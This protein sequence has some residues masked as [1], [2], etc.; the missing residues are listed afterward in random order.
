M[1]SLPSH[2]LVPTDFSPSSEHALDYACDLAAKLGATVHVLNVVEIP[3]LGVPELG[4]A[5][6]ADVIDHMLKDNEAELARTCREH[7]TKAQLG[8]P[9]MR[10]GDARDV[11][12]HTADEVHADLIVMATHGRRGISRAL[13]GSVAEMVVRLAP[14]PVLTVRGK[15]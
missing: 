9:L 13:I 15:K 11:I 5:M 7:A 3:A 8:P 12:L 2:I 4:A 14:I 1:P 6:T 10:T